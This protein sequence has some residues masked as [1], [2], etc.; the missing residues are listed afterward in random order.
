MLSVC[1]F[2][3]QSS[4][5][6]DSTTTPDDRGKPHAE[7]EQERQIALTLRE[8]E[9]MMSDDITQNL[10]TSVGYWEKLL[11]E[12]QVDS[13]LL[14]IPKWPIYAKLLCVGV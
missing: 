14:I 5:S 10:H 12:K 11:L 3:M 1:L 4:L 8:E 13:V 9:L 2:R 7:A 6:D